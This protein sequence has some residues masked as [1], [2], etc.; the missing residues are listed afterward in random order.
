MKA[1][2]VTRRNAFEAEELPCTNQHRTWD[3][4][5]ASCDCTESLAPS[6]CLEDKD[7]IR[8]PFAPPVLV[9]WG[10]HSPR[11]FLTLAY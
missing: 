1:L 8:L 11:A 4:S 3:Q 9:E 10:N 5:K 6:V 2:L 7:Y